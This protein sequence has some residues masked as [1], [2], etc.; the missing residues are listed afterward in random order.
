M[1]QTGGW[2]NT[3]DF[4]W[5]GPGSFYDYVSKF[6]YVTYLLFHISYISSSSYHHHHHHHQRI[7]QLLEIRSLPFWELS[8][9]AL[10]ESSTSFHSFSQQFD[11]QD[12][13]SPPAF[14]SSPFLL[15]TALDSWPRQPWQTHP[16]KITAS[17]QASSPTDLE[18]GG[19]TAGP[20]GGRVQSSIS[21]ETR[22]VLMPRQRE[23]KGTCI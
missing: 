14:C 10:T 1:E 4:E 22:L 17:F 5:W 16:P 18:E 21:G 7:S 6:I 20:E 9:K 2:Y 3:L 13:F 8:H 11:L 23:H 12:S 15:T 19:W